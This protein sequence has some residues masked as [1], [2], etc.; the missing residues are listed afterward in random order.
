MLYSDSHG[1]NLG[2][3]LR[4]KVS[5]IQVCSIVKPGATCG[6]V[7]KN[8]TVSCSNLGT[9]DFVI[10][11]AGSNDVARN[12]RNKATTN[13]KETVSKL[14][15]TNIL[16]CNFPHRY[17]LADTS[18]VNNETKKANRELNELS[19]EFKN[20]TVIDVSSLNRNM[21][22][23]HGMHLNNKGKNY[24]AHQT[25]MVIRNSTD[26]EQRCTEETYGQQ[27]TCPSAAKQIEKS[28]SSNQAGDALE[29]Y[30]DSASIQAKNK[31]ETTNTDIG[32]TFKIGDK[33]EVEHLVRD[34]T[35]EISDTTVTDI[36]TDTQETLRSSDV[37]KPEAHMVSECNVNMVNSQQIK[38]TEHSNV[39]KPNIVN[40]VNSKQFNSR[41]RHKERR[42]SFRVKKQNKKY[43]DDFL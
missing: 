11:M 7:L 22:T 13:I 10:I 26:N 23:R 41:D 9:K 37:H 19:K 1:R 38:I 28:I 4:N 32:G 21:H 18:C 34:S 31:V 15:Q 42:Y 6:E 14:Q 3:K 40:M 8:T 27:I 39:T 20:V 29:G 35:V 43:G 33:N 30:S 36:R 16:L 25:S 12:E 24:I 2:I 5:G 17:D